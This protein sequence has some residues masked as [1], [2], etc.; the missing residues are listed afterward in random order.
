MRPMI[1]LK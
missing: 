1:L